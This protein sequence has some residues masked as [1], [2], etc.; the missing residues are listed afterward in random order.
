MLHSSWLLAALFVLSV[1]PTTAIALLLAIV[2]LPFWVVGVADFL[3]GNARL[4]G[5]RLDMSLLFVTAPLGLLGVSCLW[6]IFW[7]AF[8]RKVIAKPSHLVLGLLCGLLAGVHLLFL[9]VALLALALPAT[10]F[11]LLYLRSIHRNQFLDI[12]P[13]RSAMGPDAPS[14]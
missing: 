7:L 2:G 10:A 11:A 12:T 4:G 5:P 1:V 9:K 13:E 14:Q 3:F 6:R 8:R